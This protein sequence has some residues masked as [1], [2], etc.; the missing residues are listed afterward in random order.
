MPVACR[1]ALGLTHRPILLVLG[2]VSSVVKWLG[3]EADDSLPLVLSLRM[4]EL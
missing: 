3:H 2:G 4:V 1:L